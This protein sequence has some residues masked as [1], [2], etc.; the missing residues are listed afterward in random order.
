MC[1]YRWGNGIHKYTQVRRRLENGSPL[2]LLHI[3]TVRKFSQL[4]GQFFPRD[5]RV[6]LNCAVASRVG[7][8]LQR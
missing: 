2:K 7:D 5:V 8:Q 6:P 3:H 1:V 4:T